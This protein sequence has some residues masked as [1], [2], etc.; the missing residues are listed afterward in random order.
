MMNLD[1]I[2]DM[3]NTFKQI[4]MITTIAD[5]QK[6][7]SLDEIMNNTKSESN[8][9][10]PKISDY[11]DDESITTI[12]FKKN[13]STKI[14]GYFIDDTRINFYNDTFKKYL[15]NRLKSGLILHEN[16]YVPF[17]ENG[18][19]FKK[20]YKTYYRKNRP[21]VEIPT[22]KPVSV[23]LTVCEYSPR[24][25]KHGCYIIVTRIEF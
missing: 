6:N 10:D 8:F 12:N 18:F 21:V 20:K 11:S 7:E 19:N 1:L 9:N 16:Y 23:S 24:Y 3:E 22:N 25:K 13:M 2:H 15:Y 4:N 17:D 14:T 5:K